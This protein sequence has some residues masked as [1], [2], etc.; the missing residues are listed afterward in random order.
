LDTSLTITHSRV[1]LTPYSGPNAPI[2]QDSLRLPADLSASDY[3]RW[4][5]LYD[6]FTGSRLPAY[7]PG[8]ADDQRVAL[9]VVSLP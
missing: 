3:T 2:F 1:V 4:V 6:P 9:G 5:G 7:G 8:A